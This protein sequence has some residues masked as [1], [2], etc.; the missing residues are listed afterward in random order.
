[1]PRIAMTTG[2]RSAGK[3][4]FCKTFMTVRHD[5]LFVHHDGSPE[6]EAAVWDTIAGSM[7]RHGKGVRIVLDHPNTPHERK[8]IVARLHS[9]GAH[10]VEAWHF[11][12]PQCTAIRWLKELRQRRIEAATDPRDRRWLEL[13]ERHVLEEQHRSYVLFRSHPIAMDEGFTRIYSIDPR[14][15]P[16]LRVLLR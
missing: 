5:V 7:T 10:D 14:T 11:I 13:M 4:T 1:M 3:T 2:P 8:T 15:P 9:L 16:D 6:K 12:T